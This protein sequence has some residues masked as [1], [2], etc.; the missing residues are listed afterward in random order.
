M[1]ADQCVAVRA[2]SDAAGYANLPDA[3]ARAMNWQKKRTQRS[4]SLG[5]P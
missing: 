2:D 4:W 3:V 1:N 5:A